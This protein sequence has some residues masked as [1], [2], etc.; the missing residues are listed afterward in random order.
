MKWWYMSAMGWEVAVVL[1]VNTIHRLVAIQ[2]SQNHVQLVM[3]HHRTCKVLSR[4]QT[5]IATIN[6]GMNMPLVSVH[7]YDHM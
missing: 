4:L 3:P 6:T 7:M 2:F 1:L 5:K